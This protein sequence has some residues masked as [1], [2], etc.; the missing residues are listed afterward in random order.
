MEENFESVVDL[1]TLLSFAF[2][3]AAFLFGSQ[4]FDK[5]LTKTRTKLDFAELERGGGAATDLHQNT[6]VLILTVDNGVDV[7][8]FIKGK[9]SPRIIYQSGEPKPLLEVLEDEIDSFK[10]AEDIQIVVN[11]ESKR[12]NG[13]LLLD[14]ENWL[15]FHSFEAIINFTRAIGG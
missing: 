11:N 13:N 4:K 8:Y 3:V 12:V 6:L 1:F 15:A 14:L 9:E 10:K 7:I 5:A 2:I